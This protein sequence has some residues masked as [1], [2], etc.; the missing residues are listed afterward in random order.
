MYNEYYYCR[1]SSNSKLISLLFIGEGTKEVDSV[2]FMCESTVESTVVTFRQRRPTTAVQ[3][4]RYKLAG[5]LASRVRACHVNF[6]LFTGYRHIKEHD[7][8]M[9]V[10]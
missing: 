7:L 3:L 6:T 8:M 2:D 4:H 9:R 10:E 5:C 1:V